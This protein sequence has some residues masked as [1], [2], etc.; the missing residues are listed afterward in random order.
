MYRD[1]RKAAEAAFSTKDVNA[2]DEIQVKG[3]RQDQ[4]LITAINQMKAKLGVH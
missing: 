4:H 3:G 2:L 1:W